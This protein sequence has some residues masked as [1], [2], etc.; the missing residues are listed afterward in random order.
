M[1]TAGRPLG[2]MT[3][4]ALVDLLLEHTPESVHPIIRELLRRL[5]DRQLQLA[6]PRDTGPLKERAV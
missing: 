4:T 1:N 5:H 3:D 6:V 2:E